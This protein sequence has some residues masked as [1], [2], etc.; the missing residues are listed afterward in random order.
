[1][2]Q[3]ATFERLSTRVKHDHKKAKVSIMERIISHSQTKMLEAIAALG[4]KIEVLVERAG[5]EKKVG[6]KARQMMGEEGV[7]VL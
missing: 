2:L 4:V 3:A 7:E 6:S 5:I 1:L